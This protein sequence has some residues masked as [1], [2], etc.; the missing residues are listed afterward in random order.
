M[1]QQTTGRAAIVQS[2]LPSILTVIDA[3]NA[4]PIVV[5]TSAAHGLKTNELVLITGVTGNTAANGKWVAFVLSSTTFSLQ[6]IP[7]LA[8]SMGSG[9]YVS[10]GNAISLGYG[11]TVPIPNDIT[12]MMRAGAVNVPFEA[13]LDRLAFLMYRTTPNG[14]ALSHAVLDTTGAANEGLPNDANQNPV[15]FASVIS[16]LSGSTFH[17]VTSLDATSVIT[18]AAG[19]QIAGEI[20]F[21]A[22]GYV[23]L[24]AQTR[25]S[26]RTELSDADHTLYTS[27]ATEHVQM[28]SAPGA[29]RTLL[30]PQPTAWAPTTAYVIGDVRKNGGNIYVCDTNG[31]SAGSG[32][33]TGTG[34]NIVDGTTRWDFAGVMAIA[35]DWFEI[36]CLLGNSGN[37]IQIQR[38]TNVGTNVA[39]LTNSVFSTPGANNVGSVRVQFDGTN[40]RGAFAGG[41]CAYGGDW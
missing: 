30:L 39:M 27:I 37:N 1:S 20:K 17:A 3:S 31:T 25:R 8:N 33:P 38:S 28:L 6:V 26:A 22:G 11:I 36:T 21:P 5:E 24:Y 41:C 12:D 7:T 16:L 9:A 10:G 23:N 18:A 19:A 32:G 13:I 15:N 29:N 40:W 14:S 2:D 4:S 35:G 34:S